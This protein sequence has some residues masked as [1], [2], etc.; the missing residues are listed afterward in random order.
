LFKKS[1][2]EEDLRVREMGFEEPPDIGLSLFV[3]DGFDLAHRDAFFRPA[4][5]PS[6]NIAGDVQEPAPLV[7]AT[8]TLDDGDPH[9]DEEFPAAVDHPL[10]FNDGVVSGDEPVLRA[11]FLVL[12]LRQENLLIGRGENPIAPT[13]IGKRTIF[14]GINSVSRSQI[15]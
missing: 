5:L 3:F 2:R 14:P 13:K 6:D 11:R 8:P 9:D 15:S 10:L 7:A 12:V 4:M 1:H